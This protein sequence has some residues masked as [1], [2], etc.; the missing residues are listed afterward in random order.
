MGSEALAKASFGEGSAESNCFFSFLQKSSRTAIAVSN[1]V[2]GWSM[3]IESVV[4]A[5]CRIFIHVLWSSTSTELP[6]PVCP[7]AYT[8]GSAPVH[9]N[10]D[11]EF[12]VP[13]WR[14]RVGE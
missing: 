11:E 3:V 9:P 4:V 5:Q 10:A 7:F 6:C 13:G 1:F 8:S 14:D 2:F 12:L